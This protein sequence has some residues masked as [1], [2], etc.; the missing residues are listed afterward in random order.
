ML[1]DGGSL[2]VDIQSDLIEDFESRVVIPLV[3]A[4]TSPRRI[5]RLHPE[6]QWNGKTYT[7]ATHL[8]ATLPATL[9]KE[10]VGNLVGD[11]DRIVAAIDMLITGV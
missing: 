2:V 9:L 1:T 7:L 3:S 6:I 4:Q 8:M 11:R 5:S 10:P